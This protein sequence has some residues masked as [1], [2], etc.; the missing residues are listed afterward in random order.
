[1]D[2]LFSMQVLLEVVEAG[3][4]S[5][6]ARRLDLSAVMVGNHVR[7]LEE[8][9]GTR[10][11]ERSTRSQR[12]TQAGG[13]YCES[14]RTIL[15][16]LR[17]T[18]NAI[19]SLDTTPRGII[20]ISAPSTLGSTLI[21]PLISQYLQRHPA[22]KIELVLSNAFVNLIDDQFDLAIRIGVLADSEL[23]ARPLPPY[24]MVI[25]GTPT[26]LAQAG[27]PRVPTDLDQ[28]ACLGH[29]SVYGSVK[30][31]L[32]GDV[33]YGWPGSGGF[34]SNDGHALRRAALAHTGLILQPAVLVADDLASGR[35]VEVL[36][37]YCPDARQV[38]LI[39]LPERQ[40]HRKLSSLIDFILSNANFT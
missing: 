19:E 16:Q 26:Y 1:M 10:L 21:A 33:E 13:L 30:W 28:H 11:I 12:L 37:D 4:F 31:Q 7:R 38:N 8:Q 9:L 29:L 6:A 17:L 40:A 24:A 32:K 2:K 25:C 5:A 39:Y 15:A 22:V 34:A 23:I 14:A 18:E 3:S 27:T 35:L 36:R 20:R